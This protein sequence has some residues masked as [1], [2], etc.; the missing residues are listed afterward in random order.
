MCGRLSAV[1]GRC[2]DGAGCCLGVCFETLASR[3]NG[4]M[5]FTKFFDFFCL[6]EEN[7]DKVTMMQKLFK[8]ECKE[9]LAKV[10]ASK[11]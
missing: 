4:L 9:I 11:V 10:N 3:L 5:E 1:L 8:F 6:Q 7:D 2:G